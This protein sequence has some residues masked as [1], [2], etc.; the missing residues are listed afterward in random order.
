MKIKNFILH[1]GMLTLIMILLVQAVTIISNAGEEHPK[2][3]NVMTAKAAELRQ[4]TLKHKGL[5]VSKTKQRY[6]S[7]D[8]IASQ[9]TIEE[10]IDFDQYPVAKVVA[11]GYTAGIESTGKTE[12]HPEYGITFSGVKVKRDLYSTIAADLTIYPIGTIL[13]IPDY[14]YGVVADKGSAI[15]GNKIDLFYHTVDDVFAQWGKREL[16]VY[17]VEMGNG[18]LTEEQLIKLNEDEAMQVFRQQFN[19]D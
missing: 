3:G 8:E 11:T 7:S 9:Q 6:I 12:E 4:T 2:S 16:E 15:K 10:A 17:I 1:V 19:E 14:G 5:N 13:Y 18:E